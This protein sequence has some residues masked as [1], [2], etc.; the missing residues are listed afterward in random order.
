M[1]AC[2]SLLF[3]FVFKNFKVVFLIKYVGC[4]SVITALPIF[5]CPSAPSR[6]SIFL[7]D[8]PNPK[9]LDGFWTAFFIYPPPTPRPQ[10]IPFSSSTPPPLPSLVWCGVHFWVCLFVSWGTG[11]HYSI[12]GSSSVVPVH[13]S[14]YLI[15]DV[16]VYPSPS[17]TFLIS[18]FGYSAVYAPSLI[19]AFPPTPCGCRNSY[20]NKKK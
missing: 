18:S 9:I 7:C 17:T 5:F 2:N 1:V 11:V 16:L 4:L 10:T 6:V 20:F 8:A 13:S 15:H 12:M 3:F 14:W 19:P